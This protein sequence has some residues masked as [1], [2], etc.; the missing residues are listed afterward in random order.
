LAAMASVLTGE[1]WGYYRVVRY[2]NTYATEIAR[3]NSCKRPLG[4]LAHTHAFRQ[5]DT[6]SDEVS[7]SC[8]SISVR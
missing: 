2:D 6:T 5:D 4:N 3:N 1:Y 7:V 8:A